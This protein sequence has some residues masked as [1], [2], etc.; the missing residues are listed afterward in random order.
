MKKDIIRYAL[1]FP[2]G[3]YLL[4]T[5]G[6]GGRFLWGRWIGYSGYAFQMTLD[7]IKEIKRVLTEG[8]I[9]F[10]A[11]RRRKISFERKKI[12]LVK[13][14]KAIPIRKRLKIWQ[15]EERRGKGLFSI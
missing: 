1:V 11:P 4:E 8:K 5:K 13:V 3:F 14:R 10:G 12:P 2:E 15:E 9:V 7:N 6:I